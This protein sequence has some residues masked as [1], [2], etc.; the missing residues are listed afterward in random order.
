MARVVGRGYTGSS[1][2]GPGV[3]SGS[4]SAGNNVVSIEAPSVVEPSVSAAQAIAG[5]TGLSDSALGNYVREFNQMREGN[6]AAAVAAAERQMEYQTASNNY[7]MA[8]SAEEA[9]KNREWQERLSNTAH[10][11]EV[12]DL[13]AAGLNPILSANGGASTPSGAVGQGYASAGAK[14]DV[15]MTNAMNALSSLMTP[16]LN[17]ATTLQSLK[18][19]D[20][21][22]DKANASAELRTAMSADAQKYASDNMYAASAVT[23]AAGE[24]NTKLR[25]ETDKLIA[26]FNQSKEYQRFKENMEQQYKMHQESLGSA[27]K[28]SPFATGFNI[29]EKFADNLLPF[30]FDFLE[31]N[32]NKFFGDDNNTGGTFAGG[33]YSSFGR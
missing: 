26:E 31:N 8:W 21:I 24:R 5:A 3:S 1:S 33:A 15:D 7:A 22:Q 20:M 4:S 2:G 17:S 27:E 18:I 23:A 14:A 11:R 25:T 9:R 6:N 28:K 19:Q 32:Y 16:M 10:Q 13:L 12:N 29:G 30:F